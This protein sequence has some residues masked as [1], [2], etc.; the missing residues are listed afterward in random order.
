MLAVVV[1]IALS[2]AVFAAVAWLIV[3]HLRGWSRGDKIGAIAAAAAVAAVIAAV[4]GPSLF[5]RWLRNR[6]SDAQTDPIAKARNEGKLGER[7]QD[8][9][10]VID[11]LRG[12]KDQIFR[13]R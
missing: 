2:G 10:A 1:L 8:E 5:E 4:I 12:V 7:K 6:E 11:R 9:Q 13:K 3:H